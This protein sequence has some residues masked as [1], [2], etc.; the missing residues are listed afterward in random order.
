MYSSSLLL[1]AAIATRTSVL[2]VEGCPFA[3]SGG[4]IPK[5]HPAMIHQRREQEEDLVGS[6][7][8]L[9][10]SP[11]RINGALDWP[12]LLEPVS[13][14][15]STIADRV[16][17]LSASLNVDMCLIR[18]QS[19]PP[20][21][22]GNFAFDQNMADL[23]SF[24]LYGDLMT[25][26]F[27]DLSGPDVNDGGIVFAGC[28]C[29]YGAVQAMCDAGIDTERFCDERLLNQTNRWAQAITGYKLTSS[30]GK[31]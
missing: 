13:D 31:L 14:D 11:S 16:S 10:G 1:V 15:G 6:D 29:G 21:E 24:V 9:I 3:W 26:R 12:G 20:P 30:T 28:T 4:E 17:E 25:Q 18:F 27:Y 22:V 23:E 2:L 8:I 19:L 7:G 5:D